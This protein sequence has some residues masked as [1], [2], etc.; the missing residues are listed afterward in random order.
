MKLYTF[1]E[2]YGPFVWIV[3]TIILISIGIYLFRKNRKTNKIS[4]PIKQ[5][6]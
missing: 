5:D 4:H 2:R 6:Q 3:A 1:A